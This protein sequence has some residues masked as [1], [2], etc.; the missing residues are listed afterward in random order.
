[1]GCAFGTDVSVGQVS[2]LNP[3]PQV[4]FLCEVAA[5]ALAKQGNRQNQLVSLRGGLVLK[6]IKKCSQIVNYWLKSFEGSDPLDR[7]EATVLRVT[8]SARQVVGTETWLL[9]PDRVSLPMA[10]RCLP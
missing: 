6:I 4:P 7:Y 10:G 5:L 8:S 2:H 9:S 1:M 3:P